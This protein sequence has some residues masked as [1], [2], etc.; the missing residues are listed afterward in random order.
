HEG[1]Q[2]VEARLDNFLTPFLELVE[3]KDR[4][5]EDH[6]FP[7]GIPWF[8]EFLKDKIELRPRHVIKWARDGWSRA[9][10]ALQET[11]GLTWLE[12]WAKKPYTADPP[13]TPPPPEDAIDQK[14]DDKL[15]EQKNQRQLDPETL[16]PDADNL[17]GLALTLLQ[18]CLDGTRPYAL[19]DVR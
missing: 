9:Q 6:L 2:I 12:A 8:D 13:P 15:A 3:V 18:Q 10:R 19:T 7:L 5:Q 1:R 16:P 17:A 4:V 14:V 11:D